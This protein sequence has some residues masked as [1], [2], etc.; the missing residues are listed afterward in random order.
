[1]VKR[2]NKKAMRHPR[3]FVYERRVRD[4]WHEHLYAIQNSIPLRV[5]RISPAD[6]QNGAYYNAGDSLFFTI[7]SHTGEARLTEM[8]QEFNNA[9]KKFHETLINIAA[10]Y[11]RAE[12][13]RRNI[14]RRS[15]PDSDK[16]S[17]SDYVLRSPHRGV[18]KRE[19]SSK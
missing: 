15:K 18:R 2:M 12:D 3:A 6:L 16:Y 13:E 5:T 11:Q 8:A 7:D 1:M 17:I 14:R 10:E 19:E 4:T 9:P